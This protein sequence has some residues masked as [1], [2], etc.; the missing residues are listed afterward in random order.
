VNKDTLVQQGIGVK[1]FYSPFSLMI[2]SHSSE[3]NGMLLLCME[4]AGTAT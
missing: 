1:I 4:V 2:E 3:V